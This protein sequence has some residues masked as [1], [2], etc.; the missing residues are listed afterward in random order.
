LFHHFSIAAKT[1]AAQPLTVN[2][3]RRPNRMGWPAL[4]VFISLCFHLA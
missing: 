2:R 3:L 4:N 1:R